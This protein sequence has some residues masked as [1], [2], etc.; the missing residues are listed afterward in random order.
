MGKGGWR[1]GE[2]GLE[3]RGEWREM[4][5]VECGEGRGVD[6]VGMGR[7]ERGRRRGNGERGEG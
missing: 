1:D 2:R 5:V 6:I 3:G 7:G 4:D